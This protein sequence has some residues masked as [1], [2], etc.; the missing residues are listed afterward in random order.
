VQQQLQ[1]VNKISKAATGTK[2]RRTIF[3]KSVADTSSNRSN[4]WKRE[5]KHLHYTGEVKSASDRKSKIS[6]QIEIDNHRGKISNAVTE[7]NG[8]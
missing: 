1:T 4:V 3:Q 2:Q 7:A 8:E 6:N 5:A